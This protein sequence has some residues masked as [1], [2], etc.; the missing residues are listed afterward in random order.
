MEIGCQKAYLFCEVESKI[1][2]SVLWARSLDLEFQIE[3]QDSKKTNQTLG[4]M[5]SVMPGIDTTLPTSGR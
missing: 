5:L 2:E 3:Y 4:K 1:S